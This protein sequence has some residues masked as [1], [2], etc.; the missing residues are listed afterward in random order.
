MNDRHIASFFLVCASLPGTGCDR[1]PGSRVIEEV[2]IVRSDAPW[3][4]ST[5]AER[6]GFAGQGSQAQRSSFRWR[7]PEGWQELAPTS[8]REINLRPAGDPDAECYLTVL[9]GGAG[10]VAANVNRWRG[11]LGEP[12][13]G[14]QEL[15]SLPAATLLGR[16]AVLI[17]RARALRN[18]QRM[19]DAA[20]ARGIRL[21]PHAKTHKSPL[22]ARWQIERGA[23]GISC[24]KLAFSPDGRTVLTGSED[25]TAQLWD[26]A[27]MKPIGE[28]MHHDTMVQNVAF[29]PDG[30]TLLTVSRNARIWNAP[31]GKLQGETMRLDGSVHAVAF[32]PDGRTVLTGGG[33]KEKSA[34][35]RT[36][37]APSFGRNSGGV[38]LGGSF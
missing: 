14:G 34:T 25:K 11:Q 13:L 37:I 32:S 20:N 27:S 1:A 26:A 4:D 21:R 29:S 35:T 38:V 6:F 12:P 28:P 15:S 17:D 22:I 8:L 24:A 36:R 16:P 7:T 2:R 10:G 18:I 30:R 9:P 33:D 5:S 23:I 3:R 31:S 19:Q